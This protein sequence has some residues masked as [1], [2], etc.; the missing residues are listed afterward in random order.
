MQV[1]RFFLFKK[2]KVIVFM[3]YITRNAVWKMHEAV[4][5]L[6]IGKV[7][8]EALSPPFEQGTTRKMY[9]DWG[10]PGSQLGEE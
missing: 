7:S 6:S 3:D 10:E 4:F 8:A 5:A 2:K 9:F 1:L